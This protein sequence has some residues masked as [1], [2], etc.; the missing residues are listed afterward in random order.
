M[1]NTRYTAASARIRL[2]TVLIMIA[3]L[4]LPLSLP[5]R[6]FADTL[7]A[8]VID[9]ADLLDSS[10]ESALTSKLESITSK[11]GFDVFIV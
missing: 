9:A 4:M 2:M 11:H 7:T 5:V 6:S 10:E 1:R 3:A 8:P